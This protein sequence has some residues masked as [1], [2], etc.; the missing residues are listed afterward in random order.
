MF[1]FLQIYLLLCKC[2]IKTKQDKVMKNILDVKSLHE[3][4][5]TKL[6]QIIA[7]KKAFKSLIKPNGKEAGTIYTHR[8]KL[9]KFLDEVLGYEA[10][11]SKSTYYRWFTEPETYLV[12]A[13]LHRKR[14]NEVKYQ[15]IV[16]AMLYAL[17][18]IIKS[19]VLESREKQKF[20]TAKEEEFT[21]YLKIITHE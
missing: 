19:I 6:P 13:Y 1:V 14:K 5:Q 10:P 2:M 11:K 4:E 18:E 16:S 7:D 12:E 17:G 21:T 15:K 3:K 8:R 9:Y 20:Y